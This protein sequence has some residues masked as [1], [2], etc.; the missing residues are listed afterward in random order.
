[1]CPPLV[2]NLRL[3]SNRQRIVLLAI[4]AVVLVGGIALATATGGDDDPKQAGGTDTTQSGARTTAGETSSQEKPEPAARVDTVRI[5]GGKPAGAP[6][7][8]RWERGDTIAL[9]FTADRP[10]E[11]HV[12]GYDKEV[13]V[14]PGG[15]KVVRFKAT[16][17]GIF[18]IEDHG[19][20]ELLAKLEVRPK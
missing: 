13:G 14:G 18:E 5:K 15:A 6:K 2:V 19:T 9:R 10:G 1:M 20:N 12:H 17:E 7:T 3:V 4:A 8:L 11:V 16:L